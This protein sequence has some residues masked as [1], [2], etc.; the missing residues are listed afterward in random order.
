MARFGNTSKVIDAEEQQKNNLNDVNLKPY[1]MKEDLPVIITYLLLELP[2]VLFVNY[3]YSA[4]TI[5]AI[6]LTYQVFLAGM[7]SLLYTMKFN[8]E[9]K[10]K[11][12]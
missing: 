10:I 5:I 9:K 2:L 1:S 6:G 12:L 3:S 8:I 7:M 11:R 4:V